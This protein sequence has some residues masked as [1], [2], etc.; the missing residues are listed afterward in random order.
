MSDCLITKLKNSVL[1]DSLRH[2]DEI[3]IKIKASSGVVQIATYGGT[4]AIV[5]A[6]LSGNCYFTSETGNVNLG[7]I[8][9]NS[10]TLYIKAIGD[11]K[12]F[13]NRRYTYVGIISVNNVLSVQTEDLK[14]SSKG[15]ADLNFPK[16]YLIGNI[17]DLNNKIQRSIQFNAL[18]T[19]GDIAQFLLTV[20]TSA[21]S[22]GYTAVAYIHDGDLSV[23]LSRLNGASNLKILTLPN[24]YGDF[25]YL[26]TTASD[27]LYF[28][29]GTYAG[30]YGT[31]EGFVSK[32]IASGRTTGKVKLAFP[33][34]YNITF[35][36]ISLANNPNVVKGEFSYFSWDGSG[37]I[38]W[39]N[40]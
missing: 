39:T 13:V 26:G 5:E 24:I 29:P 10:D 9:N 19:T 27:D 17:N 28:S 30:V 2:I 32:A 4:G 12:L 11:C 31:I 40:S 15:V 7:Q 1:D 23:N 37:N 3:P 38:T 6:R 25:A 35:E 33:E 22:V 16:S 21:I 8:S 14:Y 20:N 18:Y 34:S 36:G